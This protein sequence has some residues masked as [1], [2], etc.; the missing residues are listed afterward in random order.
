MRKL[1]VKGFLCLRDIRWEPESLN[2]LIGPNASGKSS[3]LR[4][5]EMLAASSRGELGKS[6]RTAGGMEPVVWDGRA[7]TV[8]VKLQA[9]PFP[10][11]QNP[12]RDS[13][14]YELELARIGQ[15]SSYRIARE[16]D[17]DKDAA[18]N[19]SAEDII[20]GMVRDRAR[21]LALD[22]EREAAKQ[23]GISRAAARAAVR[24]L[25]QRG[26]LRHTFELGSSFLEIATG[27]VFHLG[28][29]LFMAPPGYP[30]KT[31]P[32]EI[33]FRLAP[34]SAFGDGRHPTT[35][36]ACSLLAAHC[37]PDTLPRTP[38]GARA[39]DVGCGS[40]ILA[41][42]ALALGAETALGLDLDPVAV[43]EAREN[44]RHNGFQDRAEISAAP[45]ETIPGF[46]SLICANLRVP[47]LHSLLP[48]FADKLPPG[49]L[50]VVSGTRPEE[51]RD[52][53][54]AARPGFS[55]VEAL[56][57]G[58]WAAMALRRSQGEDISLCC[59]QDGC[60]PGRGKRGRFP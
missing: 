39:L 45:F 21:V 1:E 55:L 16:L 12:A 42:A 52:L 26:T 54:L 48:G 2:V 14:V 56:E 38:S 50:L 31:A 11:C 6:V 18:R 44:A 57:E 51:A 20:A 22:A 19:R 3:L 41:L 17:M 7:D 8:A 23:A 33:L 47:T 59:T 30:A 9:S 43:H 35:R 37:L 36:M 5:L 34:G 4:L 60:R 15:G 46:F 32:G 25:V 53:L 28:G 27:G 13:L 40:G 10:E 58:G 24:S 49:G 29:L